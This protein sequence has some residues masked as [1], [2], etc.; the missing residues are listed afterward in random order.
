MIQLNGHSVGFFELQ[1]G[2]RQGCPVS[3]YLF[4]LAVEILA[5]AIRYDKSIKGLKVGSTELE[6]S[7]LADDTAL[8]VNSIQ[9]GNV[10]IQDVI[11]F[12]EHAGLKL[13][14]D[15]YKL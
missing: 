2:I 6:V 11:T 8:F 3:P 13:N 15:K 4:I 9:A 10:A 7:Q 1:R 14:Y 5:N 12:G